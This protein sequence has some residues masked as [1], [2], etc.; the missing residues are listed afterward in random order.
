ML[1]RKQA[2]ALQA[3]QFGDMA[4]RSVIW[5][6][7]QESGDDMH[8]DFWGSI[9]KELRTAAEMALAGRVG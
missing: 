5:T 4:K 6:A 3:L 7:E 2:D 9:V 8:K 1:E